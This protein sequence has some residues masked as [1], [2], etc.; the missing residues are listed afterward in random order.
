M[1]E[2]AALK[3]IFNAERF[4]HV[5][6]ETKAVYPEFDSKRF[7]AATLPGLDELGIMQRM[8]R[9]AEGLHAT[10]PGDFRKAV[11]ILRLLAPRINRGFVTLVLSDY[12]G[13]Y[14]QKHFAFSLDALKFFTP[15]GSSEFAIREYLRLDLARTL[16]VMEKWSLDQDEHVR[17]L[18]SEGCRPRLPWSFRLDD[19]VL[20]PSPTAKILDNLRADPSLYVRKSVAN[21]LNDITKDHPT[22]VLD[23]IESWDLTNPQTAWIA[24]HALRTLIKKGDRRALAVIGAGEKPRVKVHDLAISPRHVVLGESITLSFRLESLAAREQRLVVDYA[25][26]YVKK[27]GATSAKVFKLKELTLPARGSASISRRQSIRD[28]TTREHHPGL[29]QIDILI[30]GELCGTDSFDLAR[31]H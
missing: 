6:K 20:D 17:R 26:H 18:A 2:E 4:R 3:E 31:P 22:W 10:L 30:N 15:F 11:G 1:S 8:R 23:R 13:L 19:L 28:F 24:K 21:H 16:A 7:L 14:G 12:V 9:M 5:A 29:H 27:S 25:I